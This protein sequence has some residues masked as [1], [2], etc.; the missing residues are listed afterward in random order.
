MVTVTSIGLDCSELNPVPGSVC[1]A[2]TE[3]TPSAI[4]TEKEKVPSDPAVVVE[5]STES[6]NNEI[7]A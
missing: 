4:G 7:E 6:T 1:A 5:A 3:C 2:E